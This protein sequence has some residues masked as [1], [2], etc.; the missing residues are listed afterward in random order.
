MPVKERRPVPAAGW[1]L[2]GYEPNDWS[3]TE[4]HERPNR[5]I[6]G[7]TCRQCGKTETQAAEIHDAMTAKPHPGDNDGGPPSVGV[8]S[9]DFDHARQPIDKYIEK[10]HRAF[11]ANYYNLNKNEHT[12]YI[13]STK[14]LLR[15]MSADNPMSVTGWTFSHLFIEEAQSVPDSVYFKIQPTIGVRAARILATGTPDTD[16]NQ[17]WFR[18]MWL[19][20]QDTETDN[21]K[22]TEVNYHSFSIGC[23]DNKWMDW[24]TI[25]AAREQLTEREFK[26]LYLGEWVDNDGKVFRKVDSVFTGR[27]YDSREDFEKEHGREG[28]FIVSLDVAKHHDYTVMYAMDVDT[29]TIVARDRF[30]G[31]DYPIVR[32]RA[33][34]MRKK[35]NAGYIHMDVEGV[36]EPVADEMRRLDIPVI[37]YRFGVKS[38]AKLIANLAREIEHGRVV[39]P[40]E[41]T[42]LRRELKA[43]ERKVTPAGNI[44]YTAPVN[45]FDD[46]VIAVALAVLRTRYTGPSITGSY[47]TW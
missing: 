3:L 40:V 46:T 35:W 41:D 19:R 34:D 15:W 1:Q 17:S 23:Y 5:F 32:E 18:G 26:M 30:N 36:G 7:C 28:N 13:P 33:E 45:F 44:Q 38:K 8:L 16:E 29:G 4:V 31:I 47:A 12:L 21:G 9:F 2:L 43:Y 27:L 20:G 39:F 6:A 14:A 25:E 22:K 24:E 11:G 37:G 10:I 42:Q